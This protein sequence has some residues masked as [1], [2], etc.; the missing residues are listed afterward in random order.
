M[1]SQ[2]LEACRSRI[3]KH[4]LF[5][6]LQ[7][8]GL[9]SLIP[10]PH[11]RP[12]SPLEAAVALFLDCD[13]PISPVFPDDPSTILVLTSSIMAGVAAKN[14]RRLD[15]IEQPRQA[16]KKQLDSFLLGL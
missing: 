3:R 13:G 11:L 7:S 4:P 5:L 15:G 14:S 10:H 2:C 1:V 12:A 8:N 16:A 6:L 9:V